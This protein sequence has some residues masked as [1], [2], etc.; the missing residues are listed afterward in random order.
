MTEHKYADSAL[1]EQ[2][3][4]TEL[5]NDEKE[6]LAYKADHEVQDID[7]EVRDDYK[8]NLITYAYVQRT[9]SYNME[10]YL[11][12]VKFITLKRFLNNATEA[13]RLTFPE[14][15]AK[16]EAEG[17]DSRRY[18]ATRASGY[19]RSVLVSTIEEQSATALWITKQD[20]AH[21]MLDELYDIAKHGESEFV[22]MQA[23]DKF[24]SHVKIP[25]TAKA[26]ITVTAELNPLAELYTATAGLA[27]AQQGAITK[28]LFTVDDHAKAKGI[29]VDLP[30]VIDGEAKYVK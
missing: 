26:E 13:F 2:I 24:L 3:I 27:A 9:K 28:K 11:K 8:Q 5:S 17:K 7:P 1:L 14:R 23:A 30:D 16:Y 21:E 10:A 4:D 22:R 15:I 29:A 12:A 18:V 6:L 20:Q 25:E 19:N